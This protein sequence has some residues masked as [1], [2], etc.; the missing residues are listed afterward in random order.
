MSDRIPLRVVVLGTSGAGK[1]TF[2]RRLAELGACRHIELDALHW[3]PGW[4]E[5]P[6]DAFR[7]AVARALDA[8]AWVVDGNY[9]AARDLVWPSA[10]HL[11]WLDY[12]RWLVMWRVTSR[13]L[14]RWVTR[15]VICNG[16]R[17][18]LRMSFMSK[19]SILWW[20]WST[21]HGRRREYE[22][23][24]AENPF[25]HLTLMR[26]GTPRE[27]EALVQQLGRLRFASMNKADDVS[28]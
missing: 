22:A 8:E 7:A 9:P 6:N 10:T 20:A 21:F 13:T 24:F 18:S 16:N 28:A 2:A 11:V 3:S 17:E 26:V 14:R 12:P 27:A 1:S 25:P 5:V 4:V 19:D 23:L 15:E